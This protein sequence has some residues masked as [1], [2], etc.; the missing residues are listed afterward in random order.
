MFDGDM[1]R[2]DANLVS[3]QANPWDTIKTQYSVK[4]KYRGRKNRYFRQIEH[5]DNDAGMI[6]D[7][8]E[9]GQKANEKA[10]ESHVDK[11]A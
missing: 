11:Q 8:D 3:D 5:E 4:K 6:L 7:S 10:R 1:L 9:E 2:L